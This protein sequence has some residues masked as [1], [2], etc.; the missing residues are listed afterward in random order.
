MLRR[1]RRRLQTGPECLC[2]CRC[3]YLQMKGHKALS[4]LSSDRNSRCLQAT[5]SSDRSQDSSHPVPRPEGTVQG[6]ISRPRTRT[7]ICHDEFVSLSISWGKLRVHTNTCL[8]DV[9]RGRGD[10]VHLIH[11]KLPLSSHLCCYSSMV[12]DQIV[13]RQAEDLGAGKKAQISR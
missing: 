13:K 6:S 9:D 11:M 1:K 5:F 12:M 4:A 3:R 7:P 8:Y 2:R 10:A